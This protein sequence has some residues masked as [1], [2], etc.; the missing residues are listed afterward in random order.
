LEKCDLALAAFALQKGYSLVLIKG[1]K[2]LAAKEGRGIRPLL[3]LVEAAGGELRGACL[4]D[5]VVGRAAA[6]LAAYAGLAGIYTRIISTPA[7]AVL[8]QHGIEV[9]FALQVPAIL[10]REKKGLCPMEVLSATFNGPEEAPGK[11]REKL[12][13]LQRLGLGG[14]K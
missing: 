10:N 7:L 8:R 11:I 2:L 1:G 14:K 5:R 3:E 6:Y 12:G 13:E 4:G 9:A